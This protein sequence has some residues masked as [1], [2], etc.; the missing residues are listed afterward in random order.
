MRSEWPEWLTT[1][2]VK[3]IALAASKW[4]VDLGTATD[5]QIAG[6]KGRREREKE[7]KAKEPIL[8]PIV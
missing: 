7:K 1:T 2:G 6:E 3:A 5:Q 4:R 8:D